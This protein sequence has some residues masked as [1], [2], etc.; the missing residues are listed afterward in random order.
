MTPDE[1]LVELDKQ[2]KATG[3]IIR[4]LNNQ[5]HAAEV[6]Q[7]RL[8]ND[9]LAVMQAEYGMARDADL[10]ATDEFLAT[11][12]SP[13]WRE[14]VKSKVRRIFIW[15]VTHTGGVMVEAEFNNNPTDNGFMIVSHEV[16]IR[17]RKAWL[18]ANSDQ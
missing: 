3:D 8:M 10:A 5:V 7:L 17:M 1:R 9:K 12:K 13:E 11:I 14:A 4:E 18:E 16:A 2:L 6:T 15:S